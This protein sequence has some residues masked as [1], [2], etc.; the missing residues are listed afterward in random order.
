VTQSPQKLLRFLEL[1]AAGRVEL[2]KVV[3][4]LARSVPRKYLEELAS[5]DPKEVDDAILATARKSLEVYSDDALPVAL[6]T[7]DEAGK[8]VEV[9]MYGNRAV[10]PEAATVTSD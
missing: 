4:T 6:C 10:F 9:T 7:Y 2:P 5:R 1:A 3:R 8:L